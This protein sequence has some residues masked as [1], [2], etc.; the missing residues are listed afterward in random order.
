MAHSQ[1]SLDIPF[2]VSRVGQVGLRWGIAG[3]ITL[4]VSMGLVAWSGYEMEAQS[5]KMAAVSEF[6]A[7][8]YSAPSRVISDPSGLLKDIQS[9]QSALVEL[10]I[11]LPE[12]SR[13]AASSIATAATGLA[14]DADGL[15]LISENKSKFEQSLDE[16]AS[17]TRAI[18]ARPQLM[19]DR[20]GQAL[21]SSITELSRPELAS[22]PVVFSPSKSNGELQTQWSNRFVSV[23]NTLKRLPPIADKD[24]A[25]SSEDRQALKSWV[26][27]AQQLAESSQ[28]LAKNAVLRGRASQ[29]VENLQP[30]V[31]SGASVL[32]PPATRNLIK[33]IGWLGMALAIV[34][35]LCLIAVVN[36]AIKAKSLAIDVSEESK[37]SSRQG[38]AVD[39]L[40]RQIQKVVP[41]DGPILG[42]QLIEEHPSSPLFPVAT[43]F[44][45]LISTMDQRQ[46]KDR[47]IT[48]ELDYGLNPLLETIN[49][50]SI[51]QQKTKLLSE[52]LEQ[53]GISSAEGAAL[54]AR[55]IH[56]MSADVKR[57]QESLWSATA[58]LQER[59]FRMEALRENNQ[60]IAKRIKRLGESSQNIGL[61]AGRI[62][63]I[64]Q[65]L[66]VLSINISIEAASAGEVGHVFTSM[67]QEVQ[68]L[69]LAGVE[70]AQE[71]DGVVE[72]LITDA[73]EVTSTMESGTSEV[74]ESGR[75]SEQT[76]NAVR[77]VEKLV[78]PL[79]GEL[80]ALVTELEK[81]ALALNNIY[82]RQG[83]NKT[84]ITRAHGLLSKLQE[85]VSVLRPIIRSIGKDTE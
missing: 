61:A 35:L 42:G 38:D 25:L 22:M 9:S 67:A 5:K 45:R 26:D 17:T 82:G 84:D 75:L 81:Q 34:P 24:S 74:V 53:D 36:A 60:D 76:E 43:A 12:G 39:R 33:P 55:K 58:M 41:T 19:N 40:M 10:G 14:A 70:S 72:L 51:I 21:A 57:V 47:D 7:N 23:A 62:H 78:Q 50:L 48:A 4:L 31:F 49:E 20:W 27:S 3:A 1:H 56:N 15:R 16:V 18:Q 6:K 71:I 65:Q 63:T 80:A 2:R 66:K 77:D 68:R 28:V 64:S 44:N 46:R 32:H 59:G 54:A 30:V 52:T 85:G 83:T 29:T 37:E 8:L 11:P 69:A 79:S 73:S 13:A